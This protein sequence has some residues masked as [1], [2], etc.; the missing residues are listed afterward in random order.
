[1]ADPLAMALRHIEFHLMAVRGIEVE[2][3]ILDEHFK[4]HFLPNP[5]HQPVKAR[6]LQHPADAVGRSVHSIF[7]VSSA[8]NAAT[9]GKIF[10]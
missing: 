10:L 2:A 9:T 7:S 5:G 1:M 3:R 6:N 8:Q 4:Y